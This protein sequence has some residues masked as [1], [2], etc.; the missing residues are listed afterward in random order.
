MTIFAELSRGLVSASAEET[1]A[2]GA[3]LAAALPDNTALA[4][5]GDLGTGKTT[6]VRGL[7]RGLGVRANVT[8]PTYTIYTIYPGARQL[9]HMDAYRLHAAAELEH[10][11]I[12]E[13][14]RPPFLIAVEWPERIPGFFADYPTRWLELSI[15]P[16]HRH[17][18]RLVPGPD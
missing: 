4:L 18:I 8:S 9:L 14:L 1:E 11:A 6:L 2:L 15:Q 12:G 13:L 17:Q 10:L 16:D 7:A 3:R 5:R